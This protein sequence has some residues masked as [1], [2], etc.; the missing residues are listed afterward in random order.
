MS[1]LDPGSA[2]SAADLSFPRTHRLVKGYQFDAVFKS[3]SI[4]HRTDCIRILGRPNDEPYA[5]LGLIVAKR[6]LPRAV[7]RNRVKRLIRETFRHRAAE[8][9]AIDLIVQPL[10]RD[11]LHKL[12]THLETLLDRV[13]AAGI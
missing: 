7:D 8:L 11:V 2:T 10:T 5:R 13:V 1:D 12:P 6:I 4:S 9:P 3:R